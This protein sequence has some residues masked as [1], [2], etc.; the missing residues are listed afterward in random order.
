MPQTLLK[1]VTLTPTLALTPEL[2]LPLTLNLNLNG[3][4][5]QAPAWALTRA[6]SR[7]ARWKSEK[8]NGLT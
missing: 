5:V 2:S 7:R 4:V 3:T 1:T 8:Q 6:W